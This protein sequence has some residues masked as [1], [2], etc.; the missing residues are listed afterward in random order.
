MEIA[1]DGAGT[2]FGGQAPQARL[3][4]EIM[5]P[6][7]KTIG[8][9]SLAELG[10]QEDAAVQ[11][12]H[13]SSCHD[14]CLVFLTKGLTKGVNPCCCRCLSSCRRLRH[15][16]HFPAAG[17]WTDPWLCYQTLPLTNNSTPSIKVAAIPAEACIEA[18]HRQEN[19][20][21]SHTRLECLSCLQASRQCT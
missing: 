21:A 1:T 4:V 15:P 12:V 3:V 2:V 14:L 18:P 11:E 8:S 9:T 5:D 6:G 19:T 7:R 20:Q 13:C 16:A 10:V 17:S